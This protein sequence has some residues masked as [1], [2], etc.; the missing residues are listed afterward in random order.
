[1]WSRSAGEIATG[2]EARGGAGDGELVSINRLGGGL[3]HGIV[4]FVE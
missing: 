2:V 3:A 1:M 4:K